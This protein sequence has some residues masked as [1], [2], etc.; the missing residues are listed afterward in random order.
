M[1]YRKLTMLFAGAAF[2]LASLAAQAQIRILPMGDSVTSS[3]SPHDS[4]RFWLWNRLVNAGYNVDFVGTQ[5]GVVGGP[6]TDTNFDQ[7]HEG[8]PGWTTQDG[9]ENV[10]SIIAATQPDIV[11]LD[12]GANDLAQG[13][14]IPT[15][16]ANLQTIIDHF[17]A[18]NPNVVVLLAEP[19]PFVGMNRQWM[20]QLR[21]AIRKLVKH[22][23][24][25]R[26]VN[27]W[28]GF[29]VRKDTFDGM[30]PNESGEKKIAKD[31]FSQLKKPLN[32]MQGGS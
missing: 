2:C 5:T 26:D 10:D 20:S 3:F 8:H 22:E 31:F 27:L 12:L 29:N 11:L 7:D 9:V 13:I 23:T 24:H 16:I 1:K 17:Q 25:V 19:T 4:Y 15:T 30:H 18:A 14:T 32:R 28:G 6:P 21:S